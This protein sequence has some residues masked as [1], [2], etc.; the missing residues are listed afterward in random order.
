MLSR[1]RKARLCLMPSCKGKRFDLVHKFPM[2]N[3]RAEQWRTILDMRELCDLPIET[4][5]K[6]FFIC[7]MHFRKEDYKNCESRNL[8]KTAYPR[9]FLSDDSAPGAESMDEP[10]ANVEEPIADVGEPLPT[11]KTEPQTA[12][13]PP[14]SPIGTGFLQKVYPKISPAKAKVRVTGTTLIPLA[15]SLNPK[16]S[17]PKSVRRIEL[18]CY[19][20]RN[21]VIVTASAPSGVRRIVRAPQ[22]AVLDVPPKSSAKPE[23]NHDEAMIIEAVQPSEEKSSQTRAELSECHVLCVIL[24]YLFN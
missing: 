21:K 13:T 5:R 24:I 14:K 19:I 12:S 1:E 15:R 6:R 4:I 18:P 20:G 9:L 23:T 2:D 3:E 7:S 10:I 8:N 11:L 22:I 16:D 17:L